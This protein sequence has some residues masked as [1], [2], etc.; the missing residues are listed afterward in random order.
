[1]ET[2]FLGLFGRLA[3]T[4]KIASFRFSK[5][6][7]LKEKII[8]IHTQTHTLTHS[9][10]GGSRI[11]GEERVECKGHKKQGLDGTER[12]GAGWREGGS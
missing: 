6:V 3:S 9:S 8:Q 10:I 12:D 2:G 5:I 7:I 11:T 4:T 1:M